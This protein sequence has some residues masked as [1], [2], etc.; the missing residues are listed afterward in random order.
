[1]HV[2]LNSEDLAFR[3]EVRTFFEENKIK[4]GEDYFSWRE[5][6]FKKARENMKNN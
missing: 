1:M 5:S 2:E 6:W 3:E 4:D